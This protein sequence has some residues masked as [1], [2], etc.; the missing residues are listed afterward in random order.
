MPKRLSGSFVN[1]VH[2]A[3]ARSFHRRKALARFLRQADVSQKFLTGW[4]QDESKRD[5][6][7]RLFAALPN[8]ARGDDLVLRMARDLAAQTAFPDL[9]GWENSATMLE[10]AKAAVRALQA[11]L[12]KIDDQ[13]LSEKERSES[14][15]RFEAFQEELARSRESLESLDRRLKDLAARLGTQEAGYAFQDWFY[16]LMDFFE[17]QNRRPYV[18]E[19]RQID[20]SIT[21]SG[22]TYLV[23]TKFTTGQAD[24]PDIDIFFKKVTDKADNTMGVMISISGYSAPAVEGASVRQTPL[25]LMD[26]RHLY[27]ALGGSI[28][29]GEIVE[30]VRR[31]ASQ[32][33]EALLPPERF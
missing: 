9:V 10:A 30:R 24:G 22:T 23:E 21:V 17:V 18:V 29:F 13:V 15:K 26:H 2:E 33:G 27:L 12:A 16:D 14:R 8:Q 6:L 19:G 20:G 5:L 11:A 28:A 25:L 7:D 4:T 31:H 32:T 1:L 3:A